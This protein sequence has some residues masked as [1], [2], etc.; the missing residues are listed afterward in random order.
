MWFEP[1]SGSKIWD[2]MATRP[3][4]DIRRWPQ[5]SPTTHDPAPVSA[6]R[7]KGL[8]SHRRRKAPK[9]DLKHSSSTGPVGRTLTRTPPSVRLS[10]VTR[11]KCAA[12]GTHG[13]DVREYL[14]RHATIT[15]K[16]VVP[17]R[18]TGSAPRA[19]I[20]AR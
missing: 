19:P 2:D 17:L 16:P 15:R 8:S 11:Q 18:R 3:R 20:E 1:V 6:S 9:Q 13:S 14:P 7:Q 12:S 10:L 4:A 5:R